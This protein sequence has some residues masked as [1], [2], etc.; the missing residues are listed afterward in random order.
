MNQA[1]L[2]ALIRRRAGTWGHIQKSNAATKRWGRS[3]TYR[4]GPIRGGHSTR[5]AIVTSLSPAPVRSN[6]PGC[7]GIQGNAKKAP[8]RVFWALA[9]SYTTPRV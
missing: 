3:Y 7:G 2:C 1:A 4:G 5:P 9:E 8:T 6:V